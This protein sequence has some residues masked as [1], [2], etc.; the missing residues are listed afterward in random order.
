MHFTLHPLVTL[1]K[2]TSESTLQLIIY[3]NDMSHK[4]DEWV[5]SEAK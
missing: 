4:G 5:T 1:K 2:V 3:Q